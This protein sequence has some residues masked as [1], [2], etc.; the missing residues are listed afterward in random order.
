MKYQHSWYLL[1]FF[2]PY[3]EVPAVEWLTSGA[4][5]PGF[6]SPSRRLEIALQLYPR[7]DPAS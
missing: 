6:D 7:V 5:S 3:L 2:T 1:L 4:S